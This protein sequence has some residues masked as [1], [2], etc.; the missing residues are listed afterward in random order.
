[1]YVFAQTSAA[2]QFNG[3][4]IQISPRDVWLADDPLVAKY[5]WA[6]ADTPL[7][8]VIRHTQ[9]LPVVEQATAAPGETRKTSRSRG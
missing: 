3:S 7:G 8:G 2:L 5:P 1:M 4:V 6:F 9:S